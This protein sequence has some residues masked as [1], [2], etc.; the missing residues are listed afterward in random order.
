MTP[1]KLEYS[2]RM[3]RGACCR[4]F[5]GHTKPKKKVLYFVDAKDEGN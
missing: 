2:Y 5:A 1:C 4:H 3:F